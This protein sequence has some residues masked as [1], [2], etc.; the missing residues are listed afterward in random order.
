[1]KKGRLVA[2]EECMGCGLACVAS[3]LGISYQDARQLSGKPQNSSGTGYSCKCL[4]EVLNR[5]GRNY[6]FRKAED[7]SERELEKVGTI[8]C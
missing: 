6:V 8:F 4:V 7:R 2:Q 3:E 5:K 1:M